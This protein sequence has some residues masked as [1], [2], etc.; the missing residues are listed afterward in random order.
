MKKYAF[1]FTLIFPAVQ[2]MADKL[3]I[4]SLQQ[5][6]VRTISM[7]EVVVFGDPKG[8]ENLREQP[9]S[10]TLLSQENMRADGVSSM[11]DLT[12]LVPNIFIPDYGSKLTSAIYIRGVGSRMNT[13]AVGLYVDNIPYIDKSAYDFN[14]ADIERIDVLRGQ[15]GTLYG[16]NTMGGLIRA[17]TKS[18]FNYRGT[19]VRV[20]AA[21]YNNYNASFTHYQHVSNELAFSAGGFYEHAGGFFDNAFLNKKID[22]I[23]TGG[24]RIRTIYIPFV[25]L[26]FDLNLNYEY[27]DQGGYPYGL[28]GKNPKTSVIPAYNDESGYCRGLMNGG[29]NTEYSGTNFIF[30]SITG[31]QHLTDRMVMDEDFSPGNG[32]LGIQQQNQNTL[33]EDIVFKSRKNLRWEW[34]TGVFG[35]YQ[36][37][38]TTSSVTFKEDGITEMQKLID[39]TYEDT[40]LSRKIIDDTM[41]ISGLYDTPVWGAAFYHQSTFNDILFK[42]L[43]FVLGLRL[44]YEQTKLTYNNQAPLRTQSFLNEIPITDIQPKNYGTNGEKKNS[45]SSLLPKFALRYSFNKKNNI[46]I[47]AGRGNRSGGYNIQMFPDLI[48]DV[49]INR[50]DQF[51]PNELIPQIHYKPE[52]SWNYESGAHFTLWQD[53]LLADIALFST[54]VENQQ[55][56]R[57]VKSGLGRAMVNTGQSRSNGVEAAFRTNLTD[58]FSI[59]ATYGYTQATLTNYKINMLEY[60][61][62]RVPFVPEQTFSFSGQYVI[63]FNA[64]SFLDA[65]R[66]HANYTGIG[67]IYWTER[68]DAVQEPYGT[69]NGR[70]CALKGKTQIDLWIRNAL[71]EKYATFYFE[72]FGNGYAQAGKP[73]QVGIDVRISF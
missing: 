58:V 32:Y 62:N 52:Y 72:S 35:F 26:K 3:P 71:N 22:R 42:N 38:K 28:S 24:G 27:I 5:D 59:H 33:T 53:R 40:S 57:F 49:I 68:N 4:D 9:L 25:D 23:D 21:M 20:S 19:D 60:S 39:Y 69:L 50:P 11:K 65:L 1:I 61:G 56:V 12:A 36:Q 45:F 51:L 70:I 10:V 6:T 67:K 73:M 55:I 43:S 18:P 14:Y 16:R 47:S 66:F 30:N 44:G 29:L 54:R 17:Y 15:Q 8:N 41:L 46:Y 48:Q 31:F 2:T 64:N 34:I 37:L 63:K 13:P 7:E